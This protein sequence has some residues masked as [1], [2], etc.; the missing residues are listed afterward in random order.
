MTL[1]R[2]MLVVT[3][4]L[5][6]LCAALAGTIAADWPYVSRLLAASGLADSGARA[7]A[8][9][10]PVV[11]IGAVPAV[12]DAAPI[13]DGGA[14]A[15]GNAQSLDPSTFDVAAI[16]AA[17]QWAEA[18]GSVAL[19]VS[20]RGRL[21]FE[22]YWRGASATSPYPGR[23][24]SRSL[25]AFAYG[26]AIDRGLLALDDPVSRWLDE[27]QDD[28][29]GAITLRQLLQDVSGLE[30]PALAAPGAA[31]PVGAVAV[32]GA[33]PSGGAAGGL[34]R[35]LG[36]A[37]AW[38]DRHARLA[39]GNDAAAGALSIPLA[40]APGTRFAHEG[41]N[42]QLLAL[43]LER[44]TGQD[45]E[46]WFAAQVWR[47][48][49]AGRGEFRLDRASG[50]PALHCCFRTAPRDWLRLGELLAND[51]IVDGRQVL[52]RGWAA[53]LAR[54]TSNVNPRYGLQV[55]SGRATRGLREYRPGSGSGVVH[56]EDFATDEVVWLE[57]EGGRSVWA[58][59]AARLVV[60]RLG[61]AAPGW[62][63]SVLP[64]RLLR[65]LRGGAIAGADAPATEAAAVLP[66]GT[67]TVVAGR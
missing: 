9:W 37:R 67:A 35:W 21:V 48:L 49:G 39:F 24:M 11:A 3:N 62:D 2:V 33:P 16:E 17:A 63:G 34:A 15:D 28:P 50:M 51:G 23:E 53:Q 42:A 26:A 25:V 5:L 4:V 1:R 38:P 27:W 36:V 43:I 30:E 7:D 46:D 31:V 54:S 8:G 14:G 65:A 10:L 12:A 61:D 41:V 64:N 59:P 20:H 57:G 47:P 44:A 18:H 58:F 56:R 19:L 52:P 60:V 13:A 22:R 45:F 6:L 40:H 55:W 66:A 32:A 29:R